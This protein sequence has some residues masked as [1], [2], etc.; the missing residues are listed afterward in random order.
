MY[1]IETDEALGTIK[2]SDKYELSTAPEFDVIGDKYI[3]SLVHLQLVEKFKS[4]NYNTYGTS[5]TRYL[6]TYYRVSRDTNA[7]TEWLPLNESITNFPPYDPKDPMYVEIKWER[8][9]TN[10]V[11][12]IKLTD[13]ELLGEIATD[14][15]DGESPIKM[16]PAHNSLVIKPQFIFKIF[17]ITDLEIISEGDIGKLD[18]KYRFSQDYGRTVSQWE[19]LTK[20]NITTVRINPIRFFQIEYL[21]N[22]T[23]NTNAT[24]LDI[25]LI[26]DFQNVTLDGQKTN[27]YGIRE[28]CNCLKLGLINDPST[29]PAG[30]NLDT[31]NS[32]IL[33][34]S[35]CNLDQLNKPLTPDEIKLLFKPYQQDQAINLLNKLSN[36]SNEVF[37]HEV[38]YFLTDPDKKGIDYTFH[39]YQLYNYVCSDLIKVSVENN[40]FPDN[41]IAFNQFDLAL[42]D[43]FEIHIPK[44]AFKAKFGVEKR[45]SKEDFLWF[46]E[47]NRMYQ[48][49]H[50]QQF[51]N[52]NNSAIYWKII[53]KKFVQKANI[54]GVNQTITDKV[55]ELTKNSTIDELFGKEIT[56]DKKDVA[57]KEQLRPL[58][59]DVL[60]TEIK[61][62]INRELIMNSSTI[63]SKNNYDLSMA[64]FGT[65]AVVYRNMR[66]YFSVSDNFSYML[67]FNINNYTIN[68]NYNFIDYYD[69]INSKGFKIDLASDL[70]TMT[71]N[72][73]TYSM[74]LGTSPGADGLKEEVWYAYLINVDQRQRKIS[75]WIYKRNI[76]TESQ[77]EAEG[78]A[79]TKLLKVYNNVVNMTP[80]EFELESGI[81]MKLKA[82]DM[83]A[84]NIRMFNDVVPE[85]EHNKILNQ[86]II[87]EDYKNLIFA[88]NANKRLILP[89]LSY[90]QTDPNLVRTEINKESI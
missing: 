32:G 68:D 71:L 24:I 85:S 56:L 53:L 79:S 40:Q 82:S 44:Q 51:R 50:A 18:I 73:A 20:E 15:F 11:G 87:G 21:I 8:G 89:Y 45:P 13:Y 59:R 65:D 7:W 88:D 83:K 1:S 17:K 48:V 19:Q 60:R 78:L 28:N 25:N 10:T 3:V 5:L 61:V 2:V 64:D 43:S 69:S 42:F 34:A 31:A 74:Q 81:V 80:I 27:L 86:Y 35:N 55:K 70:I 90:N 38:V 26:G 66:N 4:F 6:E 36:D 16:T 47:I 72:S 84:T 49:E 54:I 62:D 41:Q 39:E 14:K 52:F 12:V 37:G 75:Q 57:N 67:W 23:G 22:Y 9:G 63:V 46:C 58:T 76:T 29:A 33:S 77:T 30:S